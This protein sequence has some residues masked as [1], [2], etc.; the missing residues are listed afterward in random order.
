MWLRIRI[1]P[2]LD[3]K[4]GQRCSTSHADGICIAPN[5]YCD[6]ATKKCVCQPN[7]FEAWGGEICIQ[8][9]QHPGETC[10]PKTPG[11]AD[12][13]GCSTVCTAN[14]PGLAGAPPTCACGAKE[15]LA[16]T[17]AHYGYSYW[18]QPECIKGEA[19][20]YPQDIR[21]LLKACFLKIPL[22]WWGKYESSTFLPYRRKDFLIWH[23]VAQKDSVSLFMKIEMKSNN[24]FSFLGFNFCYAQKT[25]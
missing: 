21:I 12:L 16:L 18:L 20:G 2:V 23:F 5:S 7:Y 9:N 17:M 19:M 6:P 3:R 4:I 8:F 13:Q 11:A 10:D 15:M 14:P 25:I 1:I 22:N 24:F